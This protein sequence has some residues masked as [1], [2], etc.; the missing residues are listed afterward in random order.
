[1]R[2]T[3][4]RGEGSQW[5]VDRAP[6]AIDWSA[7]DLVVVSNRQPFR[8]DY[9]DDGDVIVDRPTGGL[10]AGLSAALRDSGGTWV[11]WGDG[12]ADR[13]VVDEHD[14]VSV[15]PEADEDDGYTLRRVWLTDEQV[16]DYYEGFA[17]Q[18]LWPLC[19]SAL[20]LVRDEH[21]FW[22]RYTEVNELFADA[23]TDHA[24]PGGVVWLQDYHFGVAPGLLRERLPSDT[25]LAQFWH[26]P[27]PSWDVFRTCPQGTEILEGL[28]GNDLLG[29]HVPRYCRS[30]VDCVEEA[31]PDARVDR[32]RG[33]VVHEGSVTTVRAFPMGV[34]VEEIR[35]RA[36]SPD[37][38][39][40][41]AG[42]LDDYG[43]DPEDKLVIGVDRLDYTKG[44]PERL[45]GLERLWESRP[46]WREEVTYVQLGTESRSGIPAY[47][48]LQ[49][50]V[51]TRVDEVN[52]AVGTADWQPVVY[53][54][55]YVS[56]EALYGLFNRADVGLVTPLRDG[57]NLV[58]QE[59]IAAQGDGDGVL[60]LSDQAGAH[61]YLGEHTVSVTPQNPDSIA[62]GLAEALSMSPADR[63]WRT[64][65]LN[66][67]IEE[68]DIDTWMRTV[69]GAIL[70]IERHAETDPSV[71]GSSLSSGS[72]G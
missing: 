19:H 52:E 26:I 25:A 65:A 22:E 50:R 13:D 34:P 17:N 63:R 24:E 35:E 27:W 14:C 32:Q 40:A 23:V 44:I 31:L 38:A 62:D 11:A 59:F 8:H 9:D 60:V 51:A 36:A 15:P 42:F 33:R 64:R 1:M 56:N 49:E 72:G 6:G 4:T 55:D 28:L 2:I 10:T 58:A 47:Q 29:F 53:T 61:D 70:S 5:T 54:T 16:A 18:V 57:M 7:E 68:N 20:S 30:F 46:E 21:S 69:F 48:D 45:D 43:I 3:D 37:A 71:D 12:S 66:G 67:R 39:D 41:A